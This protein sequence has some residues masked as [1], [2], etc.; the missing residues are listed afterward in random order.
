MEILR[1]RLRFS[2]SDDVVLLREVV[3]QNPFDNPMLW[4]IVQKNVKSLTK[5]DFSLRTI[6]EHLGLII[7]LWLK[8]IDDLKDY[9]SGMI[10]Q[11]TEKQTLCAEVYNLM[12]EFKYEV[13]KTKLNK[14]LNTSKT[15]GVTAREEAAKS[16]E[17]NNTEIDYVDHDIHIDNTSV[18]T[19]IEDNN[20]DSND[21]VGSNVSNIPLLEQCEPQSVITPD[22]RRI[23]LCT[24]KSDVLD[25]NRKGP[26]KGLKGQHLFYLNNYNKQYF[27]L[28][29]KE[30]QLEEKKL[31]LEERK[32]RL[33]EQQFELTS[34]ETRKK[35]ELQEK[36]INFEIESRRLLETNLD[37]QNKLIHMLVSKLNK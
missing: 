5:K 8:E 16:N 20:Y 6:K 12:K 23:P 9:R 19:C 1:K 24:R 25:H 31:A 36:Q 7:K 14:T 35:L 32:L 11:L 3:G 21:D 29:D 2:E 18:G 27:T 37:N 26:N 10:Y 22:G 33:A 34:I 4:A 30:I 17:L 13:K 15:L 28:R